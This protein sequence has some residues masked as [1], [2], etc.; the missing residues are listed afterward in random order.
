MEINHHIQAVSPTQ[1]SQSP[2]GQRAG[3]E[4]EGLSERMWWGKA[5]EEAA[6][7][8]RTA[9][10]SC[11]SAARAASR[12]CFHSQLYREPRTSSRDRIQSTIAFS[13]LLHFSPGP[14]ANAALFRQATQLTNKSRVGGFVFLKWEI[15]GVSKHQ[16]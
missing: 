3:A 15:M 11:C 4:R 7:E 9:C 16:H 14:H 1:W 6:A 12:C 8:T 10:R 2:A 13:F 5:T